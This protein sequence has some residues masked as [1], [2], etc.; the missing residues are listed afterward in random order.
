M[1]HRLPYYVVPGRAGTIPS[2]FHACPAEMRHGGPPSFSETGALEELQP[3]SWIQTQQS[4]LGIVL[5]FPP[6]FRL[7]SHAQWN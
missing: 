6:A 7:I 1:H 5:L 2:I 4:P 3:G